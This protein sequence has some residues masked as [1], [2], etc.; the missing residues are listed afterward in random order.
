M[1]FPGD[2]TL[3]FDPIFMG[4]AD[5]AARERLV[6]RFDLERTQPDYALAFRFDIVLRGAL[7]TPWEATV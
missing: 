5:A 7:E 4:I 6:S 2:P 1:Y 3:P